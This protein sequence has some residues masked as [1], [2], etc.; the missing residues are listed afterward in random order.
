[1]TNKISFVAKLGW[2]NYSDKQ[3]DQKERTLFSFFDSGT[4]VHNILILGFNQ[5]IKFQNHTSDFIE[6][7]DLSNWIYSF[8]L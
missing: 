7:R 2:N 3:G 8:K 6:V 1:M 5:N 4:N